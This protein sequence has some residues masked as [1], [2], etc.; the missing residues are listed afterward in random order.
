MKPKFRANKL[1]LLAKKNVRNSKVVFSPYLKRILR[2]YFGV[3]AFGQI[4]SALKG[5]SNWFSRSS[6]GVGYLRNLFLFQCSDSH[7]LRLDI[8]KMLEHTGSA[9]WLRLLYRTM[10]FEEVYPL[11]A[12]DR[13]MVRAFKVLQAGEIRTHSQRP[14]SLAF[15][16]LDYVG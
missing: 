15:L 7:C 1:K 8:V 3:F 9:F 14:R 5:P 11:Q 4:F 13:S 10:E 12:R 2:Y 16:W 6:R